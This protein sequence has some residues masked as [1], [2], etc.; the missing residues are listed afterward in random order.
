MKR[1]RSAVLA[2]AAVLASCST[3]HA[4]H[5]H[6]LS[7]A[8]LANPN[9][10]DP[11]LAHDQ[12][13]IGDDL[14]VVQTLTGLDERNRVV[15]LL[16]RRIP[17]RANGGISKD[18]KRITY[19]LR[20]GVRFAD[21]VELTS[22]DVAFTY[23]AILDPANPVLSQDAY[24]RIASLTTP[25]RYTV[26]VRLKKPWNAAVSDLFAQSD[27]AFGI[28]PA[29]AFASTKL[30]GAAWENHAFG[31]GPFRVASWRRGDRVILVPN[32]YFSPKPKLRR[33][34]LRMIRDD[35]TAFIALQTHDVDV[36]ALDTPQVVRE[37]SAARGMQVLRTP[38]NGT[39]WLSIQ[40]THPPGNDRAF[41]RAV[42]AALDM[43]PIRKT[44]Q[45]IFPQAG[46]FLPPVM[47]SDYDAR[48]RPYPHDLARARALLGGR[49]IAAV[50]VV[51]AENPL[52]GNIAA[53][54]QQQLAA[55]GI[56][57]SIKAFPAALFNAPDGPVRNGR[58]TLAIDGWLGGADPEQSIVFN[59][60]QA[61]VNGDNIS[62]FCNP[63]FEALFADQQTTTDAAR[64]RRD[65][66]VMQQIVHA[67]EP[68]IPLYYLSWFDGVD[69][70]VHGFARNMLEYP[71]APERWDVTR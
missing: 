10:L 61:N 6:V 4:A 17:T 70:H 66:I 7:I 58:F 20:R 55:A 28:L 41:R 62:R 67:D 56:R 29:H 46:S 33:I 52:W 51:Q 53:V 60:A 30:I 63:R 35:N 48:I 32:P 25:D 2:L 8:D 44:F 19:R 14:L 64:R 47:G 11:L 5:P 24:R 23:H 38:L 71:V 26:V 54:I 40:S 50:I 34:E 13:T 22:A 57:A 36:A 27:F 37:A 68:V 21:G 42:A 1:A 3:G 9:S 31:T 18:G 16:L 39:E 65:F 12:E 59:C 69:S 45:R 15:P 49:R 43:G